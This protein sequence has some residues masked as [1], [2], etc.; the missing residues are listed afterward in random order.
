MLLLEQVHEVRRRPHAD[1]ALHG[2]EH[3]IELALGHRGIRG[4]EWEPLNL[5]HQPADAGVC[6][7]LEVQKNTVARR[8][9]VPVVLAPWTGCDRRGGLLRTPDVRLAQVALGRDD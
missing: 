3:D 8:H 7:P 6:S 1:Q 4:Y 5:T 2:V 9:R